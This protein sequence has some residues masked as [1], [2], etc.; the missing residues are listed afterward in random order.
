MKS[1]KT[2]IRNGRLQ[3]DEVSSLPE[4]SEVEL[5]VMPM[6]SDGELRGMTDEEQGE[7][8][9]A[10]ES[11]IRTVESLEPPTVSDEEWAD[12]LRE[13]EEV[14]EIN[15]KMEDTKIERLIRAFP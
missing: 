12:L 6:P 1:L 9:E 4:G 8:P 2:K 15:L 13:R 14:K 11:W 3:I 10:I 5:I 7:T